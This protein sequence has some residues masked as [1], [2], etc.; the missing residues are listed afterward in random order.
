MGAVPKK[1]I[2]KARRDRRRAHDALTRP[3]LVVCEE[4]GEMKRP[5]YVCEVCGTYKGIKVLPGVE[6]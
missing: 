2:S 1:R 3:H 5:H 6:A 4:C